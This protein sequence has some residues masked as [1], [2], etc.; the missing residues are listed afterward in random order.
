MCHAFSVA[1]HHLFTVV[2]MLARLEGRQ[3][4]QLIVCDPD[5]SA[6]GRVYIDSERAAYHLSSTHRHHRL[7]ATFDVGRN[8]D[9]LP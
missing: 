8:A 4:L 6:N 1:E 5:V 7:E 3:L 2:E 9:G